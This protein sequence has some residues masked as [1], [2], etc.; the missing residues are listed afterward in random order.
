MDRKNR[1]ALKIKVTPLEAKV[2]RTDG[3]IEKYKYDIVRSSEYKLVRACLTGKPKGYCVLV[4]S[5]ESPSSTVL[6]VGEGSRFVMQFALHRKTDGTYVLGTPG[7]WSQSTFSNIDL[8]IAHCINQVQFNPEPVFFTNVAKDKISCQWYT[9]IPTASSSVVRSYVMSLENSEHAVLVGTEDQSTNTLFV[10]GA[11]FVMQY[12]IYRSPVGTLFAIMIEGSQKE[13]KSIEDVIVYCVNEARKRSRTQSDYDRAMEYANTDDGLCTPAEN[14]RVAALK[15]DTAEH[16]DV[17]RRLERLHVSAAKPPSVH[18]HLKPQPLTASSRRED[19]LRYSEIRARH[20][21]GIVNVHE[22][23]TRKIT[24][25]SQ[26]TTFTDHEDIDSTGYNG[27]V[28]PRDREL[29]Y[30]QLDFTKS[31]GQHKRSR[32][33]DDATGTTCCYSDDDNNYDDIQPAFKIHS[34]SSTFS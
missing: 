2:V 29:V 5:N 18:R 19:D 8:V 6:V 27:A 28:S 21:A 4:D 31:L 23:R 10:K 30:T 34:P 17:A 12:K 32:E 25:S 15:R 20:P 16:D 24:P 11:G 13:F 9:R 26:K 1:T 14:K 22:H 7:S 3:R 33:L